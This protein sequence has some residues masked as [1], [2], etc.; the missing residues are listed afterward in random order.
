M[1]ERT[2]HNHLDVFQRGILVN[3]KC[4]KL[5]VQYVAV[6][7]WLPTRYIIMVIPSFI[8][9]QYCVKEVIHFNTSGSIAQKITSF[10]VPSFTKK[11][12][13]CIL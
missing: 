3:R 11:V 4:S 12:R 7:D 13:G 5:Y 1:D 9:L 2:N 8:L 10:P 6:R